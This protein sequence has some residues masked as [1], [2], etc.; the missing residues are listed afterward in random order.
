VPVL[1]ERDGNYPELQ[2]L[3]EEVAKLEE[4]YV[5]VLGS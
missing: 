1:L 2:V 4:I 5:S 3:L